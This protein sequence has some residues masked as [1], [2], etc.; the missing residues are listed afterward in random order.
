MDLLHLAYAGL[1]SNL[2]T[3]I[4]NFV[5]ADSDILGRSAVIEQQFGFN[6][7]HPDDATG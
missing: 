1:V 4:D 2:R 3:K 6:V 7:A 5:T